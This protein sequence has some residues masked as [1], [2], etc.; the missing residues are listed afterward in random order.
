MV[1][2][3]KYAIVGFSLFAIFTAAPTYKIAMY[4]G[5]VAYAQAMKEACV[6]RNGPC[7][8][9]EKVWKT[10]SSQLNSM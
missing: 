6:G 2:L 8:Y 5:F 4:N 3:I 10:V 1:R 7:T 9:A